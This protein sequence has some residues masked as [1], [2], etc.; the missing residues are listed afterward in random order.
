MRSPSFGALTVVVTLI[1]LSLSAPTGHGGTFD[2]TTSSRSVSGSETDLI[3]LSLGLNYIH[4][5]QAGF[6]ADNLL[7]LNL[8]AFVNATPRL[9]L[10]GEFMAD[11]GRS[12]VN[13]FFASDITIDSERLVYVFGPRYTLW[14]NSRFRLC[15]E[16]LAGGVRAE[17]TLKQGS[18]KRTIS[19]EAFA[20]ATGASL[21]W[22][23]S[24]HFLWRVIQA[25]YLPTTLGDEWQSNF[26]LSTSLVYG[27]GH[28]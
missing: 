8:S 1:A 21:D 6:E 23:L 2:G 24:R 11:Y 5:D 22:H 20:A 12:H 19:E 13:V 9:A 16:L 3:E 27:F 18:F 14:E 4:L 7:G 17:A 25:D 15:A 26:R 28:R 10:G